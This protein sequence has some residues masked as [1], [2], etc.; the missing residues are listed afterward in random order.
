M[1]VC[2]GLCGAAETWRTDSESADVFEWTAESDE[3]RRGM[4]AELTRKGYD[5][6]NFDLYGHGWSDAP[7]ATYSV[8]LFVGTAQHYPTGI[9]SPRG[10]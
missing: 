7:S 1:V 5:V 4:S 8:D 9:L 6:L 3:S 10:P 2:H